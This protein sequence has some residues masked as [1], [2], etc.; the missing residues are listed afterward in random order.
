VVATVSVSV[1]PDR[2]LVTARGG[3]R[4]ERGSS[5]GAAVR[6]KGWLLV[7]V[8][9]SET[10]GFQSATYARYLRRV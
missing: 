2:V 9:Y 8:S 10:Y 4:R 6:G 3:T 5:I 7:G 1:H